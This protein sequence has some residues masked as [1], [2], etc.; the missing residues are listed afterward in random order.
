M[1]KTGLTVCLAVDVAADEP[2]SAKTISS[3]SVT[4]VIIAPS[5]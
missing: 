2:S 1:S 3:P 4:L 5:R